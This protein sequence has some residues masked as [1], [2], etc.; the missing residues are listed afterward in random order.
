LAN[1]LSYIA[2]DMAKL[3]TDDIT[4]ILSLF[5]GIF[6]YRKLNLACRLF[7][8]QL[9]LYFV[10]EVV[11]IYYASLNNVNGLIFNLQIL[12]ESI[13]ILMAGAAILKNKPRQ[14]FW[15]AFA[16]L[17]IVWVIDYT[18]KGTFGIYFHFAGIAQGFILTATSLFILF[19]LFYSVDSN[20]NNKAFI[21][22]LVGLMIYSAATIPYLSLM[23]F[24]NE[25]V[26]ETS[27][28]L[29]R[30]I[31]MGLAGLRY[32]LYGVG[33]YIYATTKRKTE[34]IND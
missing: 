1:F 7:F 14:P 12:P 34:L 13:L 16:A 6:W 27:R 8:W 5:A 20:Q 19:R 4:I 25:N 23:F 15:I 29:F 11:A 24:F 31:V 30:I 32:L 22:I 26:M 17:L 2:G 9:L 33:F 21:P 3:F 28:T 18:I 10:V